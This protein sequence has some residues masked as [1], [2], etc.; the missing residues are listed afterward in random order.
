MAGNGLA[1]IRPTYKDWLPGVA[2]TDP[3][4]G[5]RFRGVNYEEGGLHR[6]PFSFLGRVHKRVSLLRTENQAKSFRQRKMSGRWGHRPLGRG[7][8]RDIRNPKRL[9]QP[10]ALPRSRAARQD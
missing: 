7:G 6:P 9:G 5:Y 8:W 4:L 2:G 1:A 10:A 3:R